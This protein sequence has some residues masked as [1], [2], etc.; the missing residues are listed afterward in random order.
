MIDV[1][2]EYICESQDCI[3]RYQYNQDR[4]TLDDS[5][6]T[7]FNSNL[8]RHSR[9]YEGQDCTSTVLYGFVRT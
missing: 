9:T 8:N 3:T 2:R 6:S 1:Q 5:T 4:P 7:N